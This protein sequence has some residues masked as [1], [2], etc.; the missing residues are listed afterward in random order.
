MKRLGI[1]SAETYYLFILQE[2]KKLAEMT[3]FLKRP[4]R[5]IQRADTKHR[6][7]VSERLPLNHSSSQP[8]W[9]WPPVERASSDNTPM[10]SSWC[11]AKLHRRLL[12]YSLLFLL[13]FKYKPC[14]NRILWSFSLLDFL[15][16]PYALLRQICC[17][18]GISTQMQMY[19]HPEP[20]TK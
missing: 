19:K 17:F 1:Q 9:I 12:L 18:A 3:F 14:R 2:K 13:N 11:R 5:R 15:S 4:L 10:R 6:I 20:Q 8:A 16:C 7:M